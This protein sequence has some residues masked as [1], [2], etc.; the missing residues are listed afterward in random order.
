M[1]HIFTWR[2][3]CSIEASTATCGHG[4]VEAPLRL[5]I[6]WPSNQGR[7]IAS[8]YV[9]MAIENGHRNSEFSHE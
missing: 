4:H 5:A 6:E 1:F 3:R 9:K 2:L 8:G 7:R